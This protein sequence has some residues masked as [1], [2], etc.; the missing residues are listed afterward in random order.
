MK[1]YLWA[2][3]FLL[4]ALGARGRAK[5]N[6]PAWALGPIAR[7]ANARPAI[8]PNPGL[9]FDGPIKGGPVAWELSASLN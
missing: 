4:L 2:M 8:K 9:D 6:L 3:G 7:P 5:S 1:R